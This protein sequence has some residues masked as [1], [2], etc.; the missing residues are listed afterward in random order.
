MPLDPVSERRPPITPQLAVR[1]AGLGVLALILFGVVFFRLWYLQ[2]LDGDK[3]LAQARDNRVRTER[4][5]APRGQIVDANNLTLVDNRKATVVSLDPRTI[6]LS[7]RDAAAEWGQQMTA[8]SKRK[9]GQKGPIPSLP[10]P[11]A[12]LQARYRRLGRV[13]QMSPK[14]INERVVSSL[15]QLPYANIRLRIDVT[16]AERDY[17]EERHEAFPGVTVE[18]LYMR[19][20]PYKDL[21]A[22]IFGTVGQIT[23]DQLQDKQHYKGIAPGTD[24]GQNGLEAQYDKFLRGTDGSYRIEVNAAGERRREVAGTEPQSGQMLKLTLDEGLQQAAE[25]AMVRAGAGSGPDHGGAFVAM[26]PQTGAIYAMGSLPSYDPQELNGHFDTTAEYNAKFGEAAGSPLFN[27]AIA[28]AY[29]TGSTFKPITALAA[30]DAGV[31]SP[32]DIFNDEG[33]LQIGARAVD[34]AC[35]AGDEVNG[36]INLVDALRVSSDVYFYNLGLKLYHHAG[37]PL[38][39]WARKMGLGRPTGVDLPY[40]GKGTIPG[41]AWV[42][43]INREELACRKRKHV[44]SCGIG[45]GDAVW[46]PGNE[47]NT[48]VG[49]GDVQAT[50]LQM[51]VVYS[52]LVTGGKVP[53]PHLA[54]EVSDARGLVQQLEPPASRRVHIDP[55]ARSAIMEGLHQAANSP[56]GTS[57]TVFDGWPRNR[58][59]V[60][61]K[62]GTAERPPHPDQSWYVAYSYDAQHPDENPIV[63]VTTIE[64]G[65]FGAER[66]APAARQILSKFFNVPAQ[67]IAGDSQTR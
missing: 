53:T 39:Q 21:A 41:P 9:K 55:T 29:P 1:V 57:T 64:G 16:R 17:I 58:F 66:A 24:I 3:Y 15:V 54:Q 33:C 61:G 42:R 13:L 26:N 60:Y 6:P 19:S 35:N 2:V 7:M 59:P 37:Q 45:T 8:R 34:R 11:D 32:S 5:E 46:N 23:E 28:G 22:Q 48:A 38:Q 4:I 31:M 56:G 52:T 12:G 10:T 67:W 50:P 40:E 47:T 51:A 63:V 30:M 49:Q 14:T 43:K 27:R 65:G 44:S 18:Q 25:R 20:Y 62:T 36:P